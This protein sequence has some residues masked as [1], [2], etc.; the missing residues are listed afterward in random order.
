[1]EATQ[2]ATVHG[3]TFIRLLA[4][5][6]E[7][8]VPPPR[9]SLSDRL[10]HW[11]DWKHAV[12]LATALDASPPDADEGPAVGADAAECARVRAALAQAIAGDAAFAAPGPA[13]VDF[14]F[15]RQR[16]VT[17]QQVMEADIALLRNRLRGALAAAGGDAAR[18][19][20]IDAVMERTLGRHERTALASVPALLGAHFERLRQ[21]AQADT[22]DAGEASTAWLDTFRND[23]QSVLLAE[24][25]VRL[26]PAQALLAALRTR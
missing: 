16:C 4:R 1:M 19:A 26:Q 22:T 5:L 6:G 18:L 17:L 2:R 24:L 3:P 10:S 14:G 8:D 20:P 13:E 12:A 9:Q 11:L 21:Q 23:M 25:D 7:A 15:F